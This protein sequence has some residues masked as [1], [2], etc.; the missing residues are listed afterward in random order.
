MSD[1]KSKLK[2]YIVGPFSI[3]N[4][5]LAQHIERSSGYPCVACKDINQI[6]TDE[7]KQ[8]KNL[9]LIDYRDENWNT[10]QP[11]LE[12][13]ADLP[14][15]ECIFALFNVKITDRIGKD[16]PKYNVQ[17]VVYQDDTFEFLEK[18]VRSITKEDLPFSKQFIENSESLYKD[19]DLDVLG[20]LPFLK[21]Q[22]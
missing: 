19:L 11:V 14:D 22:S 3:Q 15:A 1:L 21:A 6:S 9:I 7:I 12:Q 20:D 18:W 5:L 4:E 2:I 13:I 8:Q 17:N 16:V 10:V